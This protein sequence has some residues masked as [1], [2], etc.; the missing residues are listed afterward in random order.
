MNKSQT[1]LEIQKILNSP[2]ELPYTLNQKEFQYMSSILKNH[3][4]YEKKRKVGIKNLFIKKT[5]FNNNGFFIERIDG[6]TTDFSFHQCLNKENR[7]QKVRSMF[8]T[9]IKEQIWNFRDK[10]FSNSST[11]ICPI[12][13]IPVAKSNCHVDHFNPMFYE[14]LNGFIKQN[15]LNLNDI[16]IGGENQDNIMQYYFL[17]KNLEANWQKFHLENAK[18]RVT[19]I[20]GNLTRKKT[21][22]KVSL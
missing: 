11:I 21:N 8:R 9:A 13:S 2:K 22:N 19:S 3:P 10:E 15:S 14:L 4:Y 18:L 16:K 1:I 7:I 5:I 17:D 20:R 12:L 6:T